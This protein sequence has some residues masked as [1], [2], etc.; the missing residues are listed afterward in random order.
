[1]ASETATVLRAMAASGPLTASRLVDE[2]SAP[3]HPLHDSFP[4]DN[5]KAAHEYRL[6]V[7]RKLIVSIT[8]RPANAGRDIQVF[9]HV[10]SRDGEGEYVPADV[11]VNQ[12]ERWQMAKAEALRYLT[13]AER[14]IDG[15]LEAQRVYG[16]PVNRTRVDRAKRSIASA[17]KQLSG[18]TT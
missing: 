7:A 9:I 4:W 12:P 18:V 1:M 6:I 13:A 15:L 8:V 11:L 16:K 3:D 10:P 5:D 17:Q 2:A 14:S